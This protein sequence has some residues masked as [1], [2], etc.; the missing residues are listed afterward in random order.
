[1]STADLLLLIGSALLEKHCCHHLGGFFSSTAHVKENS[2]SNQ[3][4]YLRYFNL[5]L[6]H[7][8]QDIPL[9]Q[10]IIKRI[11]NRISLD[12]EIDYESDCTLFASLVAKMCREAGGEFEVGRVFIKGIC[13]ESDTGLT[14]YY[15]D[16]KIGRLRRHRNGSTS[17]TQMRR[18]IEFLSERSDWDDYVQA[19]IEEDFQHCEDCNEWE[20]NDLGRETYGGND[21]VCRD[22]LDSNYTFLDRYDAYV[23]SDRTADALDEDGDSCTIYDNDDQFRWSDEADSYVHRNYRDDRVISGYHA[24]KGNY[25]PISSEW[26][27][28]NKRFFGIELEVEVAQGDR[29]DAASA[30]NEAVNG[31]TVGEK[32][33]FEHDGSL[34]NGFEIITQPMGLDSQTELWKWLKTDLKKGLLSHKTSTCG[35]HIHVSRDSLTRLQLSKMVF[36]VNAPENQ[37]LIETIARRYSVRFALINKKKLGNAYKDDYRNRYQ[38]IN[39][40]GRETVEFRIFKG[41]LKYESMMAALEF[42]NALVNFCNDSSGSGFQ[43]TTPSFMSFIDSPKVKSETRFLRGYLAN[44]LEVEAVAA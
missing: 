19:L 42:T 38:A 17:E 26:S 8:C 30:I 4:L 23:E 31:G 5:L 9:R 24:N 44:R 32:V 34:S 1:L 13:S 3:S 37:E 43:L 12:N 16:E 7:P 41:T 35:L 28:R 21:F 25:Y 14:L 10:A 40:E 39:I 36:F 20:S 18:W 22:C 6:A 15:F 33:F 2:M 11:V 29:E 27:T